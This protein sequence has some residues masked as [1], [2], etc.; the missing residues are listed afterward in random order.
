MHLK[1]YRSATVRE[2]LARSARSSGPTRSCS[3][4]AHRC[5]ARLAR[6]AGGLRRHARNVGE[7]T[8]AAERPRVSERA[9]HL[10]RPASASFERPRARARGG[11][12][13]AD[14]RPV[15]R[16]LERRDE[17]DR[18][19]DS[20][21][22]RR[23]RPASRRCATG[24]QRS[25]IASPGA[26]RGSSADALGA[27][28]SRDRSPRS[29]PAT[30]PTRRSKCSSALPGAG[31]TTTIAK[32]AAQERARSGQRLG[33]LAADGFRVGAVEQLRLY[34]EIIGRRSPSRARRRSSTARF[35]RRR[36]ARCWSTP[37]AAR[38]ADDARGR[39]LD[40]AR[41]APRRAHASGDA[42]RR[43]RRRLRDRLLDRF[44][45]A[46]PIRV[47]LTRLDEAESLSPLV[48]VLRE[49]G[50]RCRISAPARACPT[51]CSARRRP[52][53]PTRSWVSWRA[54]ERSHER[55]DA[56]IPRLRSRPWSR[57]H[58]RQGRRRQD[59]RR[60]STSRV[61]LARLGH[62]VGILDADFGLG[63]VDVLLGLTPQW[64]LGHVLIGEKTMR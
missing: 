42:G 12:T 15:R 34:A 50:C 30:K 51:I 4:R 28:R 20:Q 2:A 41:G 43:R 1:R 24:L 45:E 22:E 5:A 27:R 47:V 6:A 49:R 25:L 64:H 63:N 17:R 7:S 33:L 26:C 3:R 13:A 58:Q 40:A 57:R 61:S 18:C 8:A 21:A 29:P 16:A 39:C 32:I 52:P 11:R 54:R 9:T 38:R 10:A 37:P 59:Q 55:V 23:S 62:R 56:R 31:K 35:S 53:L 60:R 46:R 48:G 14:A 36:G 19:A 44:G